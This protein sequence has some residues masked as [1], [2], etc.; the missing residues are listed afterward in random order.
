MH[1]LTETHW[2]VVKRFLCYFKSTSTYGLFI[3]YGSSLSLH[4]YSDADWARNKDDNT[5]TSVY[6]VFLSLI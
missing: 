5:S 6:I 2:F 1:K 4:A 3:R